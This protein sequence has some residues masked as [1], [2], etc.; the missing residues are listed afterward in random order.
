MV[1]Y[2]FFPGAEGANA[3]ILVRVRVPLDDELHRRLLLWQPPPPP[4]VGSDVSH[5][6]AHTENKEYCALPD[7]YRRPLRR[8]SPVLLPSCAEYAHRLLRIEFVVRGRGHKH[9]RPAGM[10]GKR[11]EVSTVQRRVV[12]F[13]LTALSS[14]LQDRDRT[15]GPSNQVG[16]DAFRNH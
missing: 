2:H 12:G 6:A 7:A 9:P 5:A 15:I 4:R 1:K 3:F 14:V 13:L 11:V 10:L 16:V 8:P